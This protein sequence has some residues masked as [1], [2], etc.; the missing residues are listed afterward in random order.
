VWH[1]TDDE[2]ISAYVDGRLTAAERASVEA[3]AQAEPSLHRRIAATELLAREAGRLPVVA[4]PRNFILPRAAG[5]RPA[6]A[7]PPSRAARLPSGVFRLGSVAAAGILVLALAI[8]LTR[9]PVIVPPPTSGT[10]LAP[11]EAAA[12]A[13]A[14]GLAIGTTTS[15]VGRLAAT[16]AG[17]V[18]VTMSPAPTLADAAG[19]ARS[20]PGAA[21]SVESASNGAEPAA[22]ITLTATPD[23]V[24]M[25]SAAPT[26]MT[27]ASMLTETSVPSPTAVPTSDAAAVTATAPIV[28]PLRLLALVALVAA[29]ALGA[30]G[31]LRR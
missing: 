30:L 11:M 28:T 26:T 13:R 27:T 19:D 17:L 24:A 14:T 31:W 18:I 1:V 7:A 23:T 21:M 4:V 29:A 8:E 20:M 16:T 25:E 9:A 3:R 22:S 15:Q 2:L 10:M 6:P 5:T 12:P